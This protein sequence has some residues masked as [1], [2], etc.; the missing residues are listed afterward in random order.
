MKKYILTIM[1]FSLGFAGYAQVGI[2]TASP[3]TTLDVVGNAGDTPGALNAI[4]GITVP[5]VTD[6]MTTTTT[7]GTKISQL[8]YSTNAS[9]TGYYY[10]TGAA[11]TPLVP[12]G[13]GIATGSIT[14]TLGITNVSTAGPY[15]VLDSDRVINVTFDNGS[16]YILSL[17]D[18]SSHTGRMI[19]II[20]SATTQQ[21]QFSTNSPTG[22]TQIVPSGGASLVISNG[23][24]WKL[25]RAGF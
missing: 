24:E 14:S 22:G 13:Y 8:V 1:L 20:S 15:T 5:I 4:D 6:D 2:G 7:N 3:Q 10:W 19:C 23:A 12:A 17:P 9:S 16:D 21:I 18:P 25:L 11:W